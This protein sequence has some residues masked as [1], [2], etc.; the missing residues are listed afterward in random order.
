[1]NSEIVLGGGCFWCTEAVFQQVRGVLSVTSGYS[2]GLKP[3]QPSYEEVCRG[4]T[5]YN[6]VVKLVYDDLVVGLKD[7]LQIFFE[8]HDPTSLNRQG[9]DVGTQYRSGI[10][11]SHEE[12]QAMVKAVMAE[13][14]ADFSKPLVTEVLPL[15]HFWPAEAYHHNYFVNNPQQGYCAFVVAPKVGKLRQHFSQWVKD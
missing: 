1:M 8:V 7:L 6:E 12:D 14:Q 5:G 15:A 3:A 10:Y 9:N 4:D 11:V 13:V 2:N